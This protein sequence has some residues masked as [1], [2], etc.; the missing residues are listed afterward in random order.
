MPIAAP[1]D[2][3]S[4]LPRVDQMLRELWCFRKQKYRRKAG[5]FAAAIG[6]NSRSALSGATTD[7]VMDCSRLPSSRFDLDQ[8][9]RLKMALC[10]RQAPALTPANP[11]HH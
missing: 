4:R 11:P 6:K 1:P 9:G 2:F 7:E 8:A 5:M 3:R 10:L